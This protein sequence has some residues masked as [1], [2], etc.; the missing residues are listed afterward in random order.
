MRFEYGNRLAG[1]DQERFVALQVFQC[2]DNCIEAFPVPGCLANAA[3][4]DQ[5]LRALRHFLVQIVEQH[6]KRRFL[7][8]S[9][10]MKLCT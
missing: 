9:L 1:L 4:H 3:V 10:G 7:Y 8:P 2:F 6:P 5:I